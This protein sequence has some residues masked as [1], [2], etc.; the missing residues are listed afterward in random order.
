MKEYLVSGGRGSRIIITTR[1]IKV[2]KAIGR[3]RIHELKVL[4]D[5]NSWRLFKRIAFDQGEDQ[6]ESDLLMMGNNI[7]SKCANVP[8]S[9]SLLYDQDKTKWLLF[10]SVDLAKMV[11]DSIMPILMLSCYNLTAQIKS[12]FSYC[13]VFPKDYVIERE[14][15]ISLWMAQGCLV[16]VHEGQSMEDV[17]DQNFWTLLHRFFFK[18]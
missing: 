16:P 14:V 12:C 5:E 15:L 9:A 13:S 2:A 4:S 3:S 7:V 17:G 6:V 11:R 1:S 8:L 10:E 18:L